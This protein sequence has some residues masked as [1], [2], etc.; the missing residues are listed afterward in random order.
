MSEP[1]P[2]GNNIIWLDTDAPARDTR[3]APLGNAATVPPA[4]SDPRRSTIGA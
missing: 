4:M 1:T 2:L 3:L